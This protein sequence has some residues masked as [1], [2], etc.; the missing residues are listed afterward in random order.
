[1]K[2]IEGFEPARLVLSRPV[3]TDVY[4]E[5]QEDAV[6]QIINEVRRNGD[7]ALRDYTL[8]FDGLKITSLEVDKQQIAS[9]YR[10]VDSELVSALQVAAGRI[11]SFHLAQKRR[12]R[13]QRVKAGS[14][15]LMRPLERVG[16]YVPGGTAS[17][18]STVLMT[19]IPARATATC[20]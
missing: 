9:A 16:I 14:A 18:P 1:M 11:R 4:P 3:P 15:H 13:R 10:E 8:K 19:A 6:R 5:E 7:A 2:I 12:I 17:Y 20:F